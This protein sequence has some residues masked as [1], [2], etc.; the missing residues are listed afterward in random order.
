MC[1]MFRTIRIIRRMYREQVRVVKNEY[2][3]GHI[4]CS[5]QKEVFDVRCSIWWQCSADCVVQCPVVIFS[6]DRE[7]NEK[8][9]IQ[10]SLAVYFFI[11]LFLHQVNTA[12]GMRVMRCMR[13]EGWNNRC[14]E[15]FHA[16]STSQD[17]LFR[18]ERPSVN[19][20]VPWYSNN[21]EIF[22]ITE[23]RWAW[24]LGCSSSRRR[25]SC[26]WARL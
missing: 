10:A 16:W 2:G 26:S 14:K 6:Y 19:C 18:K 7:P 12:R 20:R 24:I 11:I 3:L 17:S 13:Y 8:G 5:V 23:V 15:E 22:L 1:D 9:V 4:M 21:E 25:G